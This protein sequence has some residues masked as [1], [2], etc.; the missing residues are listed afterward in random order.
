[1]RRGDGD[2]RRGDGER[3]GDAEKRRGDG[4]RRLESVASSLLETTDSVS[5]SEKSDRN[6]SFTAK[7]T[8]RESG[9]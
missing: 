8:K 4:E 6:E 2:R 9:Q 1:M 5:V 3:R 7:E